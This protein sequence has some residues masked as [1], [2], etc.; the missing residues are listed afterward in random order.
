MK[1]IFNRHTAGTRYPAVCIDTYGD[2][3]SSRGVTGKRGSRVKHGMTAAI[4]AAII[5]V[6]AFA[7]GEKTVTS[8][9]YVDAQ[10]ALKQDKITAGDPGSVVTYNGTD[11]NGQAQFDERGIYEGEDTYT[12][13]DADKLIT[14]GLVH[15]FAAA[16]ENIEID[17]Q[18]L[19]GIDAN[20]ST[21][22]CQ[23]NDSCELWQIST[24]AVAL[25]PVGYF[26]PL[27][28]EQAPSCKDRGETCDS[29]DECCGGINCL[30]HKCDPH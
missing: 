22:T 30:N 1:R 3:A 12:N 13:D 8:K 7:E 16:V 9:A 4:L 17:Q 15:D 28:E 10:D 14:A 21:T 25:V 20:G 23:A 27:T 26:E 24:N 29:S 11:A 5:V 19:T 2:P 6:P 18:V